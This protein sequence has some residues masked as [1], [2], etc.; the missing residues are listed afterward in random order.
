MD[1]CYISG[2]GIHAGVKGD[3]DVNTC[4]D[5]FMRGNLVNYLNNYIDSDWEK[6]SKDYDNIVLIHWTNDNNK[7]PEQVTN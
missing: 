6:T 4:E 2:N 7:Y 3:E 5:S 1:S